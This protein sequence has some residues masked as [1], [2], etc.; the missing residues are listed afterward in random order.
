MNYS[1]KRLGTVWQGRGG[2]VSSTRQLQ[3]TLAKL[4]LTGWEDDRAS[5]A[6]I[7]KAQWRTWRQE[8]DER[9]QL[10]NRPGQ[11][12]EW[13]EM[14]QGLREGPSPQVRRGEARRSH[15]WGL[16]SA[17]CG[18]S[19]WE[20]AWCQGSGGSQQ[21]GELGPRRSGALCGFICLFADR[22]SQ[23]SPG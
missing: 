13:E 4:E 15:K 19:C 11:G 5:P 12:Q 9:K 7:G 23:Y 22:V 10:W 1:G 21:W 3:G 14:A 16:V 18:T 20:T 8:R 6:A 17:T 2:G